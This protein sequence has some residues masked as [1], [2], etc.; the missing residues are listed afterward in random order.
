MRKSVLSCSLALS[1]LCTGAHAKEKASPPM[2]GLQLQQIQSREFNYAYGVVFA[3]T[4]SV[5]QDL[6]YIIKSGDRETGL[7]TAE[8]TNDSKTSALGYRVTTVIPS[9]SA[10]IEPI[11]AETSRVRLTFI[12]KETKLWYGRLEKE[13][14]DMVT[15]RAAYQAAFDKI[16]S[17]A[18][19]RASIK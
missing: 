4:L 8:G 9:V 7:I 12:V 10:F 6:G 16:E 19:V 5:L 13:N 2:S 15:D 14:Q 18:F 1:L 3:S 17:A 11:S